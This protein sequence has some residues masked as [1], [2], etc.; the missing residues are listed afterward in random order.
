[1]RETGYWVQRS[2]VAAARRTRI[3]VEVRRW[4]LEGIYY[5]ILLA[6]TV[7]FWSGC[8]AQA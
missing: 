2:A 5:A 4:L 1:M 6:L 7:V 3:V 8:S